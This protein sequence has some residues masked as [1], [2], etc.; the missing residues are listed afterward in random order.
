MPGKNRCSY[1]RAKWKRELN[2]KRSSMK[3]HAVKLI[4]ERD[5]RAASPELFKTYLSTNRPE[6]IPLR[7]KP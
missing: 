1:D 4:K 6:F 2:R 7:G 5:A 3:R